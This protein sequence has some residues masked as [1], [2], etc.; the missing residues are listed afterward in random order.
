V[1]ME[2]VTFSEAHGSD[3]VS[4]ISAFGGDKFCPLRLARLA[5]RLDNHFK[6]SLHGG[7]A[8]IGKENPV[9]FG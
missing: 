5:K 7:G 3:G 2:Q 6:A 8:V 1:V 4:V 9:E